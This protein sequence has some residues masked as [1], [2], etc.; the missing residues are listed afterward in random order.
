MASVILS[1][2]LIGALAIIFINRMSRMREEAN[3]QPVVQLETLEDKQNYLNT[4]QRRSRLD[5]QEWMYVL[6][7]YFVLEK[8]VEIESV[9]A[10]HDWM[11]QQSPETINDLM[12]DMLNDEAFID[13]IIADLPEELSAAPVDSVYSNED[14][15]AS[16]SGDAGSGE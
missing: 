7:A 6:L 10:A 2:V 16:G 11:E 4:L 12:S 15:G 3:A 9:Q 1:I 14:A 13:S 5:S 8:L